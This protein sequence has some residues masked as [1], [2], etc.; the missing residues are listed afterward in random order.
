MKAVVSDKNPSP[1]LGPC[2]IWTGSTS[3]DGYGTCQAA[4]KI[5]KAHRVAWTLVNGHIPKNVQVLHKCDRPNCVNPSHLFLG[6]HARNM[7][8]MKAKGR[9]RSGT[10]HRLTLE[11]RHEI[12]R[13]YANEKISQA[14]LGAEYGLSQITIQRIIRRTRQYANDPEES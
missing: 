8:D 14:Q 6:D 4:G 11:E 5:R 9:G 13:R 1:G 12:R 3:E 10:V 7:R 2:W